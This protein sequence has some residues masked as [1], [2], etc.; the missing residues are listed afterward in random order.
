MFCFQYEQT[1]K[2]GV[3]TKVGGCSYLFDTSLPRHKGYKAGAIFA[4][5]HQPQCPGCSR[6]ELQH[7]AHQYGG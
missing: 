6:Q 3:Y 1:A 2:G 4:C 5:L 7:H